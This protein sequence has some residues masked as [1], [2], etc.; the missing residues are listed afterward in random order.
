MKKLTHFLLN[1]IPRPLLINLSI[2]ARPIIY[3][4]FK[5]NTTN[6]VNTIEK[7]LIMKE[8][9]SGKSE[10]NSASGGKKYWKHS[11]EVRNRISQS[12]IGNERCKGKNIGNENAKGNI[13]TEE[14]R[15]QMGESRKGN[16]NNGVKY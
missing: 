11:E 3:Q 14:T 9:N 7:W 1:R 13:L 8:R 16:P 15:K 10:Y 12:L 6:T 2:L 5:G 4:F